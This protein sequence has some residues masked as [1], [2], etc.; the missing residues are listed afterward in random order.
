MVIVNVVAEP[1]QVVVAVAATDIVATT[2][3]PVLLAGAT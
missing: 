3:E 2:F 1:T